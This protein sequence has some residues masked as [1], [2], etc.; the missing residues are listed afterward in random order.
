VYVRVRVGYD[1]DH[2]SR[3]IDRST[4]P[5]TGGGTMGNASTGRAPDP[6]ATFDRFV[7]ESRSRLLGQAHAFCGDMTAAHDLL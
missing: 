6:A 7:M 1:E 4:G 3:Q 2:G 5:H